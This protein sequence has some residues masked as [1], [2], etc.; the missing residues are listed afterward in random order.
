[1]PELSYCAPVIPPP[2]PVQ[3]Y[4]PPHAYI[5]PPIPEEMVLMFSKDIMILILI[6]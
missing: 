3:P 5:P 4:I 6:H 1:M 2:R